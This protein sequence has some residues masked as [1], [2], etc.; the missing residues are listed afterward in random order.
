L[1][2]RTQFS[3]GPCQGTRCFLM[4]AQILGEE[5]KMRPREVF[6]LTQ[7]LMERRWREKLPI[8]EG[9]QLQQEEL[10]AATYYDLGGLGI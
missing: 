6:R 1:Q 10:C 9:V 5:L 2:R 8:L 4:G 7:E 3:L